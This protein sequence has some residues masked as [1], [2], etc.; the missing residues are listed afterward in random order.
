MPDIASFRMSHFHYW[1][2]SQH[3]EYFDAAISST[4]TSWYIVFSR[5]YTA[6]YTFQIFI[7]RM[8]ASR[9]ASQAD[10]SSFRRQTRWRE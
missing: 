3:I 7:S 5:H 1:I 9:R 6:I 8:S 4:F 10:V 2:A